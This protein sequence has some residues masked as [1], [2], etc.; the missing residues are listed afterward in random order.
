MF[1][2]W[3]NNRKSHRLGFQDGGRKLIPECYQYSTSNSLRIP[4]LKKKLAI[5]F[6]FLPITVYLHC[7]GFAWDSAVK[8]IF[9]S[10]KFV[11]ILIRVLSILN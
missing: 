4:G 8:G 1:S 9:A 3:T 2:T 10:Y 6:F 5:C 7:S 11:T